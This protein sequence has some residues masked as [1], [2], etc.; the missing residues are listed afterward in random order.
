MDG[1]DRGVRKPSKPR[2][3]TRVNPTDMSAAAGGGVASVAGYFAFG[4]TLLILVSLCLGIISVFVVHSVALWGSSDPEKAFHRTRELVG[5]GSTGW[6]TIAQLLNMVLYLFTMWVPG[7]NMLAKHY[8]EPIIWIVVDVLSLVFAHRHYNGIV[9]EDQVPFLGHY[10]GGNPDGSAMDAKTAKWC[11][12]T[13]IET[14]GAELNLVSSSDSAN[15]L[16]NDTTLFFSTAHV[17]RLAELAGN[18][19]A[20]GASLFPVLHLGPVVDAVSELAGVQTMIFAAYYDI[21]MHVAYTILS[22]TAVMLWNLFQIALRAF[23]TAVMAVVR[24]GALVTILKIGIDL[25][26]MLVVYV[27]IPLLMAIID[28]FM[29]V[30]NLAQPSTWAVQLSCVERVC[31][32]QDGHPG[33]EIFTTFTSIPIIARVVNEAVQALLNPQTGRRF[34]EAAGGAPDV[35]DMDD[36]SRSTAGGQTCGGCFTCR[37]PEMRAVWLLVASTYGC[38]QDETRFAG[39]VEDACADGGSW[40][41]DACGPRNGPYLTFHQWHSTYTEHQHF[42][43]GRVSHYA[44]LFHTLAVDDAGGASAYTAQFVA[45]AWK[46]RN[47]VDSG[48]STTAAAPFYRAVCAAMRLEFPD[49]DVGPGH[50]ISNHTNPGSLGYLAGGFLYESC[51]AERFQLCSNPFAQGVVDSWYEVSNCMFDKPACRRD[52]EV[53]LGQCGGNESSL[54]Q[55]FATDAAKQGLSQRVLGSV[56]LSRGRANCSV[57]NRVVEIPLF[58]GL[59]GDAFRVYSTRVR[60][61]GGAL[62][63]DERACARH[64]ASCAAV[65]RV[66]E[67]D[68]TL[69]FINGRFVAAHSLASPAPPSPAPPPPLLQVYREKLPPPPPPPPPKP[70]PWHSHGEVCTP[71]PTSTDAEFGLE[72]RYEE[73]AVCVYVRAIQDERVRAERCFQVTPPSPPPPPPIPHSER[74]ARNALELQ[75]QLHNGGSTETPAA[76]EL[77]SEEEYAIEHTAATRRQ[78]G[79]LERLAS[80]NFQLRDLLEGVRDRIQAAPGRRLWERSPTQRSHDLLDNVLASSAF[81]KAPI[82][83]ITTSQCQ[84]L[85]AAI[86]NVTTGSC[87]GIAFARASAASSDLALRQCYLLHELGGCSPVTFATAI[88]S[89]RDTDSCM[90]P[91]QE[92]NP[93]CVQLAPS[94]TDTRVLDFASAGAVCAN[95]RG[96][97]PPRLPM[98]V[99]PLEAFAFVGYAR[100]RGVHSFWSE[101]HTSGDVFWTGEDGQP[102]FIPTGD[103]RCVLVSTADSGVHAHMYARL[104]PCSARLAD[105]VVCESVDA[106][107]PPPPGHSENQMLPP[108]PPPP[109]P[110]ALTAS[111]AMFTRKTVVP[112]TEAVCLAGLTDDDVGHLCVRF[113]SLLAQPTKEGVVASFTPLC[114]AVCFHSCDGTSGQDRDGFSSCRDPSCA[115]TDCGSFL[116]TEC[117]PETHAAIRRISQASCG[118]GTP[119]PP[120]G[121][122]PPPQPPPPPRS[123]P[124]LASSHGVLRLSEEE[125]PSDENC[126]PVTYDACR[127]AGQELG[128]RMGR[129]TDLEVSL[130]PCESEQELGACFVGC[131][132]GSATG[133]ASSYMYLTEEKARQFG[134]FNSFRCASAPHEYCLCAASPPPPPPPQL[135][136]EEQLSYSGRA[137]SGRGEATAF[138]RKVAEDAAFPTEYNSH[139]TRYDCRGADSGATTCARHCSTQLHSDLV[140]FSVSGLAAPPPP[141]SPLQPPLPP[142]VPPWPSPPNGFAFH[143]ATDSCAKALLYSGNECRDGGLGSLYPPRCDLGS[144]NSL[145]GPREYVANGAVIGDDSCEHANNNRCEDGGIG[146]EEHMF[147]DEERH[148]RS[149]C[150]YATDRAD[151]PLR[152]MESVGPLSYGNAGH[153]PAPAPGLPAQAPSEPPPPVFVPCANTCPI[154]PSF[155]SD[156][157]LGAFTENGQFMCDYGTQCEHCG[158]REN[159][160]FVGVDSAA[161]ARDLVCDDVAVGGPAGYG[162]DKTDCGGDRRVVRNGGPIRQTRRS[163]ASDMDVDI[164]PNPTPPPP[165]PPTPSP[166]V[167]LSMCE[168]SCVG[169]SGEEGSTDW[170]DMAL[171][172]Q[173]IPAVNTRL[174]TARAMLERGVPTHP[175]GLV[176]LQQRLVRSPALERPV[177][178]LLDGWRMSDK[179]SKTLSFADTEDVQLFSTGLIGMELSSR[180]E[181]PLDVSMEARA[182]DSCWHMEETT[183]VMKCDNSF[184]IGRWEMSMG[185]CWARGFSG[186]PPGWVTLRYDTGAPARANGRAARP[187]RCMEY[188]HGPGDGQG[189]CDRDNSG[190]YS[191]YYDW[192][193]AGKESDCEREFNKF[194]TP[195]RDIPSDWWELIGGDCHFFYRSLDKPSDNYMIARFTQ[196]AGP[197]PPPPPPSP[198]PPPPLPHSPSPHR[199]PSLPPSL[200]PSPPPPPPPPAPPPPLP[201]PPPSHPP[202][203]PPAP[204]R[205]ATAEEWLSFCMAGCADSKTSLGLHYVEVDVPGRVC[206]C[207]ESESPASPDNAAVSAFTGRAVKATDGDVS[208]YAVG[209]PAR[210]HIVVPEESGTAYFAPAFEEGVVAGTY[211]GNT[212]ASDVKDCAKS[213]VTSFGKTQTNAF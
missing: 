126:G 146:S 162:T 49:L 25:L 74:A 37:I 66:L 67:R 62:A 27:A 184:L 124:P 177:A 88:Y 132:L 142:S 104:V 148:P 64:P 183:G 198:P 18:D 16:G 105:G 10:C 50:A 209:P 112:L 103:A 195:G 93:L 42:D 96:R 24:S 182:G 205:V 135:G 128:L 38:I 212:S 191:H 31:F 6:N 157:G 200:P 156:G 9:S 98:P 138:Y 7:Y 34:G 119:T 173:S 208:V 63:I 149:L 168:C 45:D 48:E 186:Y 160:D 175:V 59:L 32:K 87:A 102:L 187:A 56:R 130:A 129:S 145:C 20:E 58:D 196:C 155:C 207:F 13:T 107:P 127:R 83:G 90:A 94:R 60:V 44:S 193:F 76:L 158:N 197:S 28:F 106:H 54:L 89:R 123:P 1:T 68:P 116:L 185:D 194:G 81:G 141:Q 172:A 118:V 161:T 75:R 40:Y 69:T 115:D 136:A 153:P 192:T 36:G 169:M 125:L 140:A 51:K 176:M 85:C 167:E 178:H 122:A 11:S 213:C 70:P 203:T 41:I 29:C 82:V 134:A 3:R 211:L 133:A 22:E 120:P 80:D 210:Q 121:T 15:T 150:G 137:Q 100:E 201:P 114:H 164:D 174:Y 84:A 204:P 71:V 95:G 188:H 73:R 79:L 14:W 91:T 117:P 21:V 97:L 23:T 159:V 143:G 65:I 139:T 171:I 78:I 151:C 199:P 108:H 77:T 47:V 35:P 180:V 206:R 46:L 101:R 163:L 8:I 189:A 17:R 52:R 202:S 92:D 113:A 5:Y 55:D 166:P 144:Q 99:S 181:E 4:W 19:N 154:P 131:S 61:R 26:V 165:P 109:P 179:P 110:L 57:R 39:R 72:R 190:M 2:K 152:R 12:F 86:T 53:C 30:V 170:S 147:F 111:L 33:L 43:A